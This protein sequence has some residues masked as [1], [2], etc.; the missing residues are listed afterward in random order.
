[1]RAPSKADHLLLADAPTFEILKGTRSLQAYRSA[2]Q[3][4]IDAVYYDPEYYY[5]T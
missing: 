2:E 3:D 5:G 1:M 4:N